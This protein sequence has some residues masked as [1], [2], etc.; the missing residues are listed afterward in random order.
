MHVEVISS[1]RLE[2]AWLARLILL[3][4]PVIGL[5][6]LWREPSR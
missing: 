4:H 6:E 1:Q 3:D 5:S 2:V